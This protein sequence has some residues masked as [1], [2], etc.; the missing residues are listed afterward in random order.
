[1]FQSCLRS[2]VTPLLLLAFLTAFT[3]NGYSQ[4]FSP[5]LNLRFVPDSLQ[6]TS[7]DFGPDEKLYVLDLKGDIYIFSIVRYVDS[8]FTTRYDVVNTEHIPLVRQIQNYNDD[9]TPHDIGLRQATG[10]EVT[11]TVDDPVIYVTSSDYRV[12]QIENNDYDSNLNTN[13]G[14]ISRLNRVN[15]EWQKVDI[16]RGLPRSEE[17]HATNGLIIDTTSNMLY[18]AQGGHTNGGGPWFLFGYL[19][20]YALSAA[21]LSVDLTAIDTMPIKVDTFSGHQYIYDLPTVD[22]PTRNNANGIDDPMTPGYDGVDINDPHGGNDGLNQAKLVPGGPVQ[23]HSGGYRNPYDVIMM[24]DGF[25]YTW[26]N[27][28][29]QNWGGKPANEGFGTATNDFILDLA[30]V[31]FN[32]DK[33]HRIDSAGYYGGHPNPIRCNPVNAGLYTYDNTGV[34]RTEYDPM[35]PSSSLPFDWPPV[36]TS[37]ASP[38]EGV[39]SQGGDPDDPS[40]YYHVESTNGLAEYT[41]TNFDSAM[42]SDLLAAGWGSRIYRIH[43]DSARNVDTVSIL[44]QVGGALDIVARGDEQAFPGTI[45]IAVLTT[46]GTG[47]ISLLEPTDLQNCTGNDFLAV[48]EDLDGYTNADEIDN[49]TDPCLGSFSPN[50]HDGT[51]ID[52]FLVSDLN[53]CVMTFATVTT[54]VFVLATLITGTGTAMFAD[55]S[56]VIV[57]C[58]LLWGKCHSDKG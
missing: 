25:L 22:D 7:L 56:N 57:H 43:F 52:G 50:D 8:I 2:C 15:G 18:V 31:M 6:A 37:M 13:S 21:I 30:T 49:G 12:N 33:L 46:N 51:L 55:L 23:V 3:G 34:F 36:D 19:T 20:E 5:A 47:R 17:N 48:D 1:M 32:R 11:G 29:N 44:A 14:T 42:T 53:D 41:A 35:N 38:Q 45:W 24:S 9:G 40:I 58:F 54:T 28:G 4:S 10:I 27:G 26:D 39:L 16:I